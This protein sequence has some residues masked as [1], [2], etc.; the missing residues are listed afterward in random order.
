MVYISKVYTKAGDG[1]QTMLADG[2]FVAKNDARVRCYGE[3]DELNAVVGLVRLELARDP[4]LA[5]AEHVAFR[6]SLDEV[7]AR[8]QQ[9]LFDLGA[10]L[11][12]PGAAAGAAKITVSAARVEALEADI[13]RYNE[14][15][16]P[17]RSFILPGGGPSATAGHLAR[18]VCRRAERAT[19]ALAE[20]SDVRPEAI[21]YLNRLSDFL[22]VFSRAVA[23]RAG[24]DEVLWVQR[25][26][27]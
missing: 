18:T 6:R 1:G 15:L 3:V 23:G 12:T 10:E 20:A 13:D 24:Y 14:P 8:I 19:V 9:E 4:K 17:L 22:F 25:S 21:R 16:A 26:A 27:T 11:A 7:L 2:R 5:S